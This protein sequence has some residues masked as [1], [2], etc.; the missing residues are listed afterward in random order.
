MMPMRT[1]VHVKTNTGAF[2]T[3]VWYDGNM[4]SKL[5]MYL[6][7]DSGNVVIRTEGGRVMAFKEYEYVEFE[8]ADG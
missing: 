4:D 2:Y 5:K 8:E 6:G 1:R 7:S 3:S